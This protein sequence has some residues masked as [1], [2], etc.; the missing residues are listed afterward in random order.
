VVT[1]MQVANDRVRAGDTVP[2]A[3]VRLTEAEFEALYVQEWEP[4]LNFL[5]LRVG[6]AEAA[7]LAGEAFARAWAARG[8]YDPTRAP[9][10]G[11]L[12][13][14]VRHAAIDWLRQPDLEARLAAHAAATDV[15]PEQ[16]LERIEDTHVLAAALG[17]LAP[18]DRELVALRFGAGH[19]NRHVADALGL[20]ESNASVRLHRALRRLRQHLEQEG[21][22]G[23]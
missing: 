2:S 22:H 8:T 1:L 6:P 9:A 5:R 17:H 4:V 3:V 20:S 23:Q 7:D 15:D 16:A 10:R 14:I 18:E 13:A 19:S 11:W 12:W 21:P